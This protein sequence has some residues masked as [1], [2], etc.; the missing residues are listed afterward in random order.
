MCSVAGCADG[1]RA[2]LLVGQIG[3]AMLT[4]AAVGT[5]GWLGVAAARRSWGWLGWWVLGVAV[6][7]RVAEFVLTRL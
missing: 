2:G 1:C 3:I 4:L 5:L 6:L 7:A